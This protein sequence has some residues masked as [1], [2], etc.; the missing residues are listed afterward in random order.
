MWIPGLRPMTIYLLW[1][2]IK[3]Q[4]L[5]ATATLHETTSLLKDDLRNKNKQ[6]TI[7]N[8][9]DVKNFT[10]TENKYTRNKEQDTKLVVRKK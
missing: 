2:Q 3:L 6:L 9:I 7:D 4:I 10:V 5:I 1:W 8:L